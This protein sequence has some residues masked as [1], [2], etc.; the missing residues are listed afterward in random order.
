MAKKSKKNKKD[1]IANLHKADQK[2]EKE[3]MKYLKVI[4]KLYKDAVEEL[5][6]LAMKIDGIPLDKPFT[7]DA[8]TGVS[9]EADEVIKKLASR[10]TAVTEIGSRNEWLAACA[11]SDEFI[12]AITKT[13]NLT[14][15]TLQGYQD[16]NLEG[17]AAFQQRKVNGLDLSDRIWKHV[18]PLKDEVE[19]VTDTSK[20]YFKHGINSG[21]TMTKFD[22]AIG[23]GMSAQELSQDI[24]SCLKE[25][26]R[27]FRRVRD[28]NGNLQLSKAAKLYH[29]GQ[30]VYR[31]S[32]KNAMRVSRSE[33]NMAY[34]QSDYDRWQKLDW[35]IGIKIQLSNNHTTRDPK[36]KGVIPLVDICDEL[37][38]D[39][40]K[41]FK[42]VGWHPQC[43]CFATPIMINYED[44]DDDREVIDDDTYKQLPHK[45]AVNDV[46]QNFKDYI[47]ENQERI[48]GWSS[49]PYYIKDNPQWFD[50]AIHPDKY[51]VK[52]LELDDVTKK[53]LDDFQQYAFNHSGS[54]LFKSA[55]DDALKAQLAGKQKEFEEAMA[56]ME[57][58]RKK[59]EASTASKAK[60]RLEKLEKVITADDLLKADLQT[61][62][63]EQ[64][65]NIKELEKALKQKKGLRMSYED[66]NT[67]K[68]NPHYVD[69][70][71]T[72]KYVK[73]EN[74]HFVFKNGKAVVNPE[75]TKLKG[76]AVN[77]QTCTVIHE[78]R[79]RGFNVEAISNYRGKV[80]NI[81]KKQGVGS[82]YQGY[83][84][85]KWLDKDG[86]P[87]GPMYAH[88]YAAQ[89]GM[90]IKNKEDV[91]K[92]F[93]EYSNGHDGRYEI[94]VD[95]KGGSAHVFC[96]ERKNGV[97]TFFDPQS[98]KKDVFDGYAASAKLHTFGIIRTDDKLINP[99]LAE[100][101][102]AKGELP[103][104]VGKK[105]RAEEIAEI[106]Q[107]RHD[108]RTDEQK[109][110]LTDFWAKRK[111]ETK[112]LR[113]EISDIINAGTGI[114]EAK[115][116][117]KNMED[118]LL[119]NKGA[120]TTKAGKTATATMENLRK[121]AQDIRKVVDE[122]NSALN[123]AKS[124]VSEFK[125]VKG[126]DTESVLKA[127]SIKDIKDEIKK[128]EQKKID[129]LDSMSGLIP[130]AKDLNKSYSL[131]ELQQAHEELDGVFSKWLSKYSYSSIDSAPLDH[132]KN[133]L[134][135][136]LSS[137]TFKYTNKDI[138]E[139]AIK[140]KIAI[141]D[142]KIE[143]NDLVSQA[144]SLKSF[145]TK[146]AKY[147][148][149]LAKVDD[150]VKSNDFDAL[151]KSIAEAEAE[152]IKIFEKM[153]KQGA[154]TALNKEY[155][156]GVVGKDLT[157][158]F[159]AGKS[160]S[161]DPYRGT[162][163]NNIA[164]MQGFDAPAKLVSPTEFDILEKNCGEVFYRTVKPCNFKG[165]D[166]SSAEF[167]SQL[168]VADLLELNGPG[169][170]V[171]GDGMYVATSAWNGSD[172][173]KLT[174]A[175]KRK[176]YNESYSYGYGCSNP[177]I[178]EMTFTRK[179]KIIKQTD[180]RNIWGKLDSAA[181]AKFGNHMNTYACALGYD[182]MLCDGPNY[183][184]IWNRSIIAV[185]K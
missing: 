182:A 97:W 1:V 68:E 114:K 119:G 67:G 94:S 144:D 70:R 51:V 132:I 23:T 75:Y 133:K 78:L 98:G 102:I 13:S 46:P 92:F 180:L 95:W 127:N 116:P 36:G 118:L 44:L 172:L 76:Y 162:F 3:T 149:I 103:I 64:I 17:L 69:F 27:L 42:F 101:F 91:T 152:Q 38:G 49:L 5:S 164:R 120:I 82:K 138:I 176:A 33:I 79:R 178:S 131:S 30:G 55:L 168:Y 16:R 185:K 74:G 136:E 166:M 141:I 156:G 100:T 143:W 126:V 135:F 59:N 80:W 159:D 73:D 48:S 115:E 47:V 123:D 24:R 165:K 158:S 58:I 177:T 148:K 2:H 175:A 66:A 161:M 155:K 117:L 154:K 104:V 40:P 57:A 14:K 60:K 41:N 174:E 56:K 111:E 130:N 19:L 63:P 35:V 21:K 112:A 89:K 43:R 11:K 125:G 83:R 18:A 65:A 28:K 6:A 8:N 163:T 29:P 121:A 52:A 12:E 61:F 124:I 107:K 4:E 31:S 15:K 109:K 129:L 146:A 113:K 85:G 96:A 87:V 183:M 169:G 37:V 167:A 122:Y 45:D 179:P 151:K 10:I 32:Y 39:Y 140:E 145:N 160:V 81:Y 20:K 50:R 90:L 137:P 139:K 157:S 147:K 184:V 105:T 128:L 171:Y 62:T 7:F 72:N 77:C 134:S 25:P 106:A 22:R 88:Q 108:A 9:K 54:K 99:K 150:A 86:K 71:N 173:K 84:V 153:A 170:R 181:K 26:N 34:R 142:K 93:E 110:K 53:L